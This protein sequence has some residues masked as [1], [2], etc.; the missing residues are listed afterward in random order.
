MKIEVL[1]FEGC[2]NHFPTLERIR[3]VLREEGFDAEVKEV[4][5]PDVEPARNTRFL[6]SPSVRVND[7]DIE[8]AA[9]ARF[10]F[11]LMCRRYPDGIPSSELIRMAL[12]AASEIEDAGQ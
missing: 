7:V 3:Q 8:P 6:G 9:N 11:G 5:V 12:R 10:D 1:Y 4:L 2:P